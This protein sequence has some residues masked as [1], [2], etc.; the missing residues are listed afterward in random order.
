MH[1]KG[2]S[3]DFLQ[4]FSSVEVLYALQRQG[5]SSGWLMAHPFGLPSGAIASPMY[6][7]DDRYSSGGDWFVALL[8]SDGCWLFLASLWH[9]KW[10]E[11]RS[12]TKGKINYRYSEIINYG[13]NKSQ[14]FIFLS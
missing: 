2:F 8:V 6:V 9:H 7:T 1:T 11:D 5:F 4:L 12:G 3:Q 13:L 14:I 10:W